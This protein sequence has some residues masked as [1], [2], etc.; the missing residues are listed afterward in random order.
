MRFDRIDPGPFF[1]DIGTAE[2]LVLN[3]FSEPPFARGVALVPEGRA[4]FG[5]MTVR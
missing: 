1:L 5:A 4:I 3:Q 2:N